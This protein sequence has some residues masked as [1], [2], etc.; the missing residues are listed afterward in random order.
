MLANT[1]PRNGEELGVP[2]FVAGVAAGMGYPVDIICTSASGKLMKIGVAEKLTLKPADVRSI[3]DLIK[4]AHAAGARF[5]CCSSA[6]DLFDMHRDD[7][8][9]EC[10]G[11]VGVA[12][13]VEE[14]MESDCRLLTY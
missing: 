10:A 12:H 3:Y 1:D 9:P 13:Y 8:I 11:V 6:L 4:D 2:F 5:Y 7:L 14:I